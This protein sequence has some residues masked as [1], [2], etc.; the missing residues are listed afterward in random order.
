MLTPYY[1]NN[2]FSTV[3]TFLLNFLFAI[4]IRA[5][6]FTHCTTPFIKLH[7]IIA[8]TT[9]TR[10]VAATTTVARLNGHLL[11]SHAAMTI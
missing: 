6:N 5:F 1:V 11:I 9:T 2:V 7:A 8:S 10:V 4:A 3:M